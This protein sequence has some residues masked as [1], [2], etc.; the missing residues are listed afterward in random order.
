MV[1]KVE[2][3]SL[4]HTNYEALQE[5]LLYANPSFESDIG[6]TRYF[7]DKTPNGSLLK[8]NVLYDILS[9]K[10]IYLAHITRNY[11]KIKKSG[12]LFASSGC[13]VGSIYC[14]PVIKKGRK[15]RLH[16][17]G[18]YIY[19]KEAPMFSEDKKNITLL[20]IELDL[21]SAPANHLVGINYLKLGFVHFS[22]FSELNYL[23][24]H[25][26]LIRLK[27]SVVKS[28]RK[29]S[30]LLSIVAEFSP[31]RISC[32]FRRFYKLYQQVIP[33]L[34]IL[35]YFLF[36][37]LCEYIAF[38]Q[39]GDKVDYY[40][41]Q[42]ELYAPNFKDLIFTLRPG[43]T[44]SFNLGLFSPNFENIVDYL[45]NIPIQKN[46]CSLEEYLARRL[47]YLI[48]SLFYNKVNIDD[49]TVN[50]FWKNAEW[51]FKYLQRGILPLMGHTIH[52]LLRNMHRYPNFYFY[53]DQYKALQVWNYW[54]HN[55][56]ILPYNAVLPKG[57]VGLNPAYPYLKYRIFKGRVWKE[58]G[59][60][61]VTAEKQLEISIEPRL[62]ELDGLLM[63]KK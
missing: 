58:K 29:A 15:L 40:R 10:K 51:D 8:E 26:E 39:V 6:W 54:N 33:E 17:L 13:L 30:K 27:N 18:E 35:G 22:A 11:D 21:S 16:N 62:A 59:N 34:P 47:H 44:N 55:D 57:E 52:R 32:N 31:E 1:N 50:L 38:F 45:K 60:S 5:R 20:L 49:K 9:N 19:F 56:I 37:V 4:A 36:E 23:L 25:E 63:R 14:T 3:W 48:M 53:F 28:I 61:Y 46:K 12:R 41:H 7:I 43:L 2:L 24:S 42:G